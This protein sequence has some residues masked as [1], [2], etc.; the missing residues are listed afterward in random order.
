[1]QRIIIS[2]KPAI[3]QSRI[4]QTGS[5]TGKLRFARATQMHLTGVIAF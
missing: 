3:N 1:M 4:V 2:E 5:T